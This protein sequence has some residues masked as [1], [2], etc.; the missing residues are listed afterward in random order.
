LTGLVETFFYILLPMPIKDWN[1]D[2]RPREKL[3]ANG[4]EACSVA[5]LI[6]ILI[7]NGIGNRS[8][9]DLAN[10]LMKQA[11]YNLMKFTRLTRSEIEKVDGIGP[12]KSTIIRAAQELGRRIAAATPPA[13]VKLLSSKDVYESMKFL[14]E[15][16]HE[17][18]WVIYCNT[19]GLFIR[20]QQ[21]G[22]GASNTVAVDPKEILR[23]A[24]EC[25]AGRII[26]CH[27]HPG[28]TCRPS[29]EDIMLTQEL[30]KICHLLKID[31]PEHVIIAGDSYYSFCDEG[32][33]R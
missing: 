13:E 15:K 5:E 10:D 7:T 14:R 17:E 32:L 27:N 29:Q 31:L 9:L 26:L 3:I 1:E 33:I 11:D 28:G 16:P 19:S 4:P 22:K 12:A 20:R 6:A 2:D 23:Y 24:F 21:I 18:F 8:A 25:N 30:Q